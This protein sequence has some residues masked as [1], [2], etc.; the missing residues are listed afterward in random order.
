MTNLKVRGLVLSA[1]PHKEQDRFIRILTSANGIISACAP[2][3]GKLGSRHAISVQP[4][5]LSD[6]AL[7]CSRGYYYLSES[8][9]VESFRGLYEDIE[10]LTFAAHLLEIASDVCVTADVASSVYPYLV[11]ALFALS[12]KLKPSALIVSAFEWKMMDLCGYTADL[13]SCACGRS[14]LDEQFAFS[15]DHCRLYCIRPVCLG[16]AGNYQVI[17]KS[18]V[19]ALRYIQTSAGTNLFSFNVSDVVLLEI[20]DL[21]RRFLCERF[22]KKYCKMDLLNDV[23]DL[24]S[25]Q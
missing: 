5:T 11:R 17:S 7:N 18:A 20:S 22:E 21:T 16:A 19:N 12:E 1:K 15:F 25:Y 23:G 10:V 4:G 3:A 9:L 13:D 24:T 14:D 2:G 6:F 8:E